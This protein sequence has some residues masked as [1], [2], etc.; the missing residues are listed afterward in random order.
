MGPTYKGGGEMKVIDYSKYEGHTPVCVSDF[1]ANT[2]NGGIDYKVNGPDVKGGI[3][4]TLWM[5]RDAPLL[6]ARCKEL[7]AQKEKMKELLKDIHS[8]PGFVP[9]SYKRATDL[10]ATMEDK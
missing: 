6:L 5:L 7:E 1:V 4:P 3:N 8:L 2:L 9:S 10:L